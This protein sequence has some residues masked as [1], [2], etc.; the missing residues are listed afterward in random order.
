MESPPQ[1]GS[2]MVSG[3]FEL[4]LVHVMRSVHSDN[5]ELGFERRIISDFVMC[6]M[7]M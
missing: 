4:A 2:E 6:L 1:P 7:Q 3:W 5:E